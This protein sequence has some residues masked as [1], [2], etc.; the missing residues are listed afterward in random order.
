MAKPL[1]TLPDI[2]IVS[3]AVHKSW[4][5][6]KIA[7]GIY[8][9]TAEDGEELMVEYDLLSEKAKEVDRATVRTVYS[10]ILRSI[11]DSKSTKVQNAAGSKKG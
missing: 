11:D 4:M 1:T 3:A 9:R 2:E 10:A 5:D 6:G 8:T 7:Q